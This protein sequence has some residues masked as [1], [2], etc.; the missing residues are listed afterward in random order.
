MR[1]TQTE[2]K[3]PKKKKKKDSRRLKVLIR[4]EML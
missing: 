2:R 1:Q 4:A 3:T